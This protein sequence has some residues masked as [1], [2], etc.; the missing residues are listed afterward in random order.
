MLRDQA[1]EVSSGAMMFKSGGA[2]VKR[3]YVSNQTEIVAT[4]YNLCENKF[5][6]R[7]QPPPAVSM[8]PL[9]EIEQI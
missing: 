9:S 7:L 2:V 4:M 5:A 8:R 1:E 3:G 6:A